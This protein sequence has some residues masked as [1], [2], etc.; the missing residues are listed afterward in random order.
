MALTLATWNSFVLAAPKLAQLKII[1]NQACDDT[2]AWVRATF[3]TTV[4]SD[5]RL[6]A[7]MTAT[8][9]MDGSPTHG[10][11]NDGH[12][13]C[14]Q[15]CAY[16]VCLISCFAECMPSH[17]SVCKVNWVYAVIRTLGWLLLC[18]SHC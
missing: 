10:H 14:A 6:G 11:V 3:P 18:C 4:F 12:I 5:T 16:C 7:A 1:Y 8:V 2:K 15:G 13:F 17:M 9:W